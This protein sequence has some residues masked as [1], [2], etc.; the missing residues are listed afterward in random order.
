MNQLLNL[1]IANRNATQFTPTQFLCLEIVKVMENHQHNCY[2]D[3][4]T[5]SGHNYTVTSSAAQVNAMLLD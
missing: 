1:T 4:R 5:G 2:A 3:I